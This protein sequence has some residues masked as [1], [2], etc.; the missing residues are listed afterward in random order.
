M[1]SN[2]RLH[3]AGISRKLWLG[4]W[5][6]RLSHLDVTHILMKLTVQSDALGFVIV[7]SRNFF[8]FFLTL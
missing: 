8:F 2:I 1:R 6:N 3:F 5:I 4:T 7:N